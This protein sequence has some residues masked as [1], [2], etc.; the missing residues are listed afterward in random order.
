M[1]NSSD[2]IKNSYVND[3]ISKTKKYNEIVDEID[4]LDERI[5]EVYDK[6][7]ERYKYNHENE[8]SKSI[9]VNK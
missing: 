9:Y 8:K 3:D 7:T 1:F 4:K 6:E 2:G 5:E